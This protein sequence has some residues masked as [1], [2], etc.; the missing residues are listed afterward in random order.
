MY[1]FE[2]IEANK[3]RFVSERE[4]ISE[5]LLFN[6][7][8]L[9]HARRVAVIP[10]SLYYYRKN[11]VSLSS[12][13]RSDRFDR[14]IIFYDEVMRRIKHNFSKAD[15]EYGERAARMFLGRVRSCVMRATVSGKGNM[16]AEVKKMCCNSRV[17]DVLRTYPYHRNPLK[18]RLFNILMAKRIIP[19]VW[20]LAKAVARRNLSK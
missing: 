3:I 12:V 4:F 19:G 9:A 7:D 13:Y 10:D 8:Y 18:Q 15:A 2:I 11:P 5:D 20:L 14:E 1:S 17:Q 16:Y 6:M